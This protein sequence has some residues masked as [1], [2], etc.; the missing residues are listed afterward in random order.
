MEAV[1]SRVTR[2]EVFQKDILDWG[3][4]LKAGNFVYVTLPSAA[5]YSTSNQRAVSV[6]RYTGQLPNKH[7]IHFGVEIQV[8][9]V[10]V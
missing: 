10:H 9:Q 6:I 4:K 3:S 5:S 2:Y 8:G 7:G 1:K